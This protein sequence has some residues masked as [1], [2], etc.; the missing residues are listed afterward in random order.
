MYVIKGKF[1]TANEWHDQEEQ[2]QY[3][4]DVI[5]SF[6]ENTW[7]DTPTHIHGLKSVLGDINTHLGELEGDMVELVL[8]DNLSTHLTKIVSGVLKE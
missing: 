3:N 6:Q 7:V 4:E 8:E 5:M 2:A 1:Q